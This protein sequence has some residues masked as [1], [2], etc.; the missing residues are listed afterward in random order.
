M[1]DPGRKSLTVL[2]EVHA[3]AME[4]YEI[5]KSSNK[6]E[7][8]FIKWFSDYVMMNLERDE[9]LKD[10]APYL[11]KIGYS[12]NM[13]TIRDHKVNNITDI[14][15]KDGRL[16]CSLDETDDCMHIHFA[17][18]LPELSKLKRKN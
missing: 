16:Y 10:Y 14:F 8:S 1:P 9:F 5:E 18:A 11:E 17:L 15:M 6:T 7:S 13:L 3:K 2:K 12:N 4:K